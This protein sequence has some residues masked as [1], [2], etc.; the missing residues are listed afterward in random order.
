MM[1]FAIRRN[2]EK[3][4][5]KSLFKAPKNIFDTFHYGDNMLRTNHDVVLRIKECIKTH[6]N[7]RRCIHTYTR[8]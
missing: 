1:V 3:W 6:T 5:V 4:Q 2:R 8:R 7:I